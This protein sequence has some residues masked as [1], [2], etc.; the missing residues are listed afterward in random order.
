MKNNLKTTVKVQGFAP[1]NL[2]NKAVKMLKNGE[3]HYT[4]NHDHIHIDVVENQDG[5]RVAIIN[6]TKRMR[7][8]SKDQHRYVNIAID[9]AYVQIA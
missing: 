4:A 7:D 2:V 6:T 1:K 8:G 3:K 9:K 5:T